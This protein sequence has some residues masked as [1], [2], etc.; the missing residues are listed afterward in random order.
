M[1]HEE[2]DGVGLSMGE[3]RIKWSQEAF[4]VGR[5]MHNGQ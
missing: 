4:E 2:D 3:N 5:I 1:G